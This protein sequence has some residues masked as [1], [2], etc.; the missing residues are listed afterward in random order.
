MAVYFMQAGGPGGP[1]KIGFCKTPSAWLGRLLIIR[2]CNHL[3]VQSLGVR[4]DLDQKHH[5][6][7]MHE[8]LRASRLRG[9][10]FSATPEV[11]AEVAKARRVNI[12]PVPDRP[13]GTP[14]NIQI[15][16]HT[17]WEDVLLQE[18]FKCCA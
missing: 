8:T 18:N 17:K 2:T 16:W 12:P 13:K 9:E 1:I 10:W 7:E 4:S 11:L 15:R 14:H 5:E 6:Q 3:D